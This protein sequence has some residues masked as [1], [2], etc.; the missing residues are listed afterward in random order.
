[1]IHCP[2]GHVPASLDIQEK[3]GTQNLYENDKP[4][5]RDF[6]HAKIWEKLE[7]AVELDLVKF[8]G[9]S[10]FDTEQ[11]DYILENCRIKTCYEIIIGSLRSFSII[12]KINTLIFF[13]NPYTPVAQ[14]VADEVVFRPH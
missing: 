13:V 14:R 7:N 1:M 2:W 9:V 4:V 11:V 5:I 8:I 6:N 12:F 10:N 3:F